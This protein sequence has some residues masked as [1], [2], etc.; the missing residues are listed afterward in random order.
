MR[1]KMW[2]LESDTLSSAPNYARIGCDLAGLLHP[3]GPPSPQL[4]GRQ[5]H[6]QHRMLEKEAVVVTVTGAAWLLEERTHPQL[7]EWKMGLH[8]NKAGSRRKSPTPT[9][10][11]Q[12]KRGQQCPEGQN[13]R[14][15]LGAALGHSLRSWYV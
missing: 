15:E 11:L 6:P 2:S 3:L 8:R 9:Q 7:S 14:P 13:Q 5:L 1:L 12:L 4:S 10:G